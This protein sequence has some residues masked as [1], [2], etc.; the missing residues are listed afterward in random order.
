MKTLILRTFAHQMVW[1]DRSACEYEPFQANLITQW[2]PNYLGIKSEEVEYA[3]GIYTHDYFNRRRY[4][5]KMPPTFMGTDEEQIP[6]IINLGVRPN[7]TIA[8][9][10]ESGSIFLKYEL[11]KKLWNAP[12]QSLMHALDS[13]LLQIKRKEISAHTQYPALS[14]TIDSQIVE[15]TFKRLG[16]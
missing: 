6:S 14:F 1:D 9:A 10:E 3:L 16:I 11:K 8:R 7:Q 12:D 15:S 5:G 4:Y 13:A 2:E